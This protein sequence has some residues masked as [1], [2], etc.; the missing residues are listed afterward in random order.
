MTQIAKLCGEP[1]RTQLLCV[2]TELKDVV[3]TVG[4]TYADQCDGFGIRG[5]GP[6][7]GYESHDAGWP[8]MPGYICEMDARLPFAEFI[9][10]KSPLDS[11]LTEGFHLSLFGSLSLGSS[12]L[13][14]QQAALQVTGNNIA[15]SGTV[16]YTR[17]SVDIQPNGSV[18]VANGESTGA[19]VGVSA[20]RRQVNEALNENLRNS[21]S[22]Q[23]A[24]AGLEWFV[25][26]ATECLQH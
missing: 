22:D 18:Q 11:G 2:A 13:S 1:T 12:S 10:L 9:C 6:R 14:A 26:F 4:S 21:T 3:Q 8:S 25:D 24:G 23:S 16:G 19:G 7:Q 17:E 15:N 5:Q 20:V